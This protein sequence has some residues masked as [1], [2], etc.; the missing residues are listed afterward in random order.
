MARNQAASCIDMMLVPSAVRAK[1]ADHLI[2]ERCHRRKPSIVSISDHVQVDHE[3]HV[4]LH[5]RPLICRM[6]RGRRPRQAG[7]ETQAHEGQRR[8]RWQRT[9]ADCSK[10]II[11]Q[12]STR[13]KQSSS[14]HSHV[15][16]EACTLTS[17]MEPS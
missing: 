14:P 17:G 9:S 16:G 3:V 4:A 11:V 6:G 8:R 1:L 7:Q 13:H 5:E 2:V 15:S 10:I 12:G